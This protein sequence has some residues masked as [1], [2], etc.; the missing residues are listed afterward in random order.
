MFS[1]TQPWVFSSVL[2][3]SPFHLAVISEGALSGPTPFT[4]LAPLITS[5]AGVCQESARAC[6]SSL[7]PLQLLYS[8]SY[9]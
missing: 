8:G 7:L 9:S 4:Q 6:A 1:E 3:A 2:P 5:S